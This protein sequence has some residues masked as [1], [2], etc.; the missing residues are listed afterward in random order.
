M[1]GPAWRKR[2]EEVGKGCG[3]PATHSL[4][5]SPAT[6]TSRAPNLIGLLKQWYRSPTTMSS[7][8]SLHP[9]CQIRSGI[10][11]GRY[12]LDYDG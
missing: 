8:L 9:Q 4:F 2:Q 12:N 6:A 11:D 1:H 10:T 7:T 5:S 3:P